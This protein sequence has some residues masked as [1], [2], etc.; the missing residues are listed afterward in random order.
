MEYHMF[1]VV[2]AGTMGVGIAVALLAA[3]TD[4]PE[5]TSP[6][7]GSA[8]I[9]VETSPDRRAVA[10]S[11]V[12][13]S[14]ERLAKKNEHLDVESALGRVTLVDSVAD[15]APCDVV[16]EAVPEQLDLKQTIFRELDELHDPHVMLASNTSSLSVTEIARHLTHP[17]RVVGMHFFNPVPV[18]ALIEIVVG[19][20]TSPQTTARA[21]RV[22]EALAKTPITVA[23]SPG[24]ASSRLGLC[25]GLEAIRM[26]EQGVATAADIDTAMELGYRHPMGPLRLTDLVGLDVRLA[27]AQHLESELGERFSPPRLL[28]DMVED[29]KT[30][31]KSGEGFYRW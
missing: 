3:D 21:L 29:G 20:Q 12:E 27:I 15:T 17:E 25:L 10:L 7:T 18:S 1:G 11:E 16:I 26:L 2:G 4:P 19:E 14:L 23:D 24:F 22:A 8:V 28:I 6:R 9:L 31:K 30:G 5:A 13:H